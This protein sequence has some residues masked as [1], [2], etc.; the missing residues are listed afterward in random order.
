MLLNT[1]LVAAGALALT[2]GAALAQ[3]AVPPTSP[4][5]ATDPF[6]YKSDKDLESIAIKP[7]VA[8]LTLGTLSDHENYYV[9]VVGRTET[10][11]PEFHAHWIDFGIVQEGQGGLV[12][13]GTDAGSRDTGNG[14]LRGGAISG[15]VVR[16]LNPGDYFEIPAGQWHQITLKPATK[17]FR[18][19]VV[20]V[21]Q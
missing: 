10:G 11:E 5:L 2:S 17:E 20:K 6:T 3:S 7:G 1:M 14:E 4:H 15:G 16:D 18:Y 8:G 12:Y 21:R 9:L 13:G 19:V